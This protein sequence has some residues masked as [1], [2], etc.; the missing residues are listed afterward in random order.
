MGFAG[1]R[2]G[3]SI[4]GLWLRVVFHDTLFKKNLNSSLAMPLQ[5]KIQFSCCAFSVSKIISVGK[6]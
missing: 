1:S 6:G 4:T 3:W 5:Y 2:K